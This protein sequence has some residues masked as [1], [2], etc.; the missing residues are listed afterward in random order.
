MKYMSG[1]GTFTY[2]DPDTK[3]V[4]EKIEFDNMP[5]MVSKIDS[6][7]FKMAPEKAVVN[8]GQFG[9]PATYHVAEWKHAPDFCEELIKWLHGK[10]MIGG[11]SFLFMNE[12]KEKIMKNIIE[13][14][15]EIQIGGV[16]LEKG[17]RIEILKKDNSKIQENFKYYRDQIK[18]I[19][20]EDEYGVRV[21]MQSSRGS[22]KWMNL[23]KDF[24]EALDSLRV[25]FIG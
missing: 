16:I 13:V 5:Y 15:E 11:K 23:N 20:P 19:L 9:R 6:T 21:Q 10:E 4:W 25:Y 22:T 7:H 24:F 18:S 3:E 17:D 1:Q 14:K 12:S 2:V 8:K